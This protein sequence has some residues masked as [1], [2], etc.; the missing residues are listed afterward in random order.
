M[1]TH[2]ITLVL[3]FILYSLSL[4]AQETKLT[5]DL[6]HYFKNRKISLS[7]P[8][9]K[10]VCSCDSMGKKTIT[11][12]L[13][14]GSYFTMNIDFSS[15]R[16]YLEP[17]KDLFVTV[18]PGENGEFNLMDLDLH[19]EGVNADVNTYLNTCKLKS[20]K[21]EDFLL[22]ENSCIRKV[23]QLLKQNEKIIRGYKLDKRFEKKELL[24]ARYKILEWITR[25]PVQHFW[26]G[27]N[28]T[29]VLYNYDETPIVKKYIAKQLVDDESLWQ[30]PTYRVFVNSA[31]GILPT[32]DFTLPWE[33]KIQQRLETLTRYFK[34][35]RILEDMMQ[36][37][38]LVYV[39]RTEGDSLNSLQTFYDKYV[40]KPAYRQ[41]LDRQ[42]LVWKGLRRGEK[43]ASS[44][45]GYQDIEGNLV[46]LEDLKGKYI[47]IDVWATWCGPCRGE[48][49]SLKKLEEEFQGKNIHF[50]SISIDN[51]RSDWVKMVEREKLGGIQLWGGPNAQIAIDYKIK[52]IPR[53]ML[54]DKE[55]KVIDKDMTR[56]S[57]PRTKERLAMLEG[58]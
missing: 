49:P 26:K 14:E 40:T 35:P 23:E 46:R 36:K 6:S 47:Y 44:E 10:D 32:I 34:N 52:G 38:A 24:Q 48:L 51:R 31:V 11:L 20:L 56:P 22:D 18:V 57:D 21:D 4:S 9:F 39:E 19:F 13:K 8:D 41:E 53:F 58:I 12:S 54:L 1:K 5:I 55:G 33:V 27:G 17:G 28:Q 7:G 37:M 42:Y 15:N 30:I 2:L 45:S 25:Y 29:S 3:F 43:I 50:V 16:L